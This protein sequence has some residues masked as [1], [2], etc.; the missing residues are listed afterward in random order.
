MPRWI[1]GG[2]ISSL[3][4]A[5]IYGWVPPALQGPGWKKGLSFG[6]GVAIMASV[7]LLGYSGIFDL[8]GK[9][10]IWWGIDGLILYPVAGAALGWF[11]DKYAASSAGDVL[12]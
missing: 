6:L 1:A 2:L 8:P 7:F 3:I 5:A 9:I 11:G 10:W 4:L 12:N